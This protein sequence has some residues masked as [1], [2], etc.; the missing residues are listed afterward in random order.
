M[1]YKYV[2]CVCVCVCVCAYMLLYNPMDGYCEGH[3]ISV[4]CT[5]AYTGIYVLVT[6]MSALYT[7]LYVYSIS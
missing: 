2:L 3:M 7:S 1:F 5:C 6:C 4:I